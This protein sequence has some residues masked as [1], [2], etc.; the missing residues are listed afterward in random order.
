[1][2]QILTA[3]IA[4][5]GLYSVGVLSASPAKADCRSWDI[6]ARLNIAQSNDT[7]VYVDTTAAE[8][9]FAGKAKYGHWDKDEVVYMD[10]MGDL[11]GTLRGGNI[12]FT[13]RWHSFSTAVGN[14]TGVY[15]GTVSPQG[16]VTGTTYDAIH[17]GTTAEWWISDVLK[18]HADA[19][20]A[21][22]M[23]VR[24]PVALGRV[25]GSGGLS[26]SPMPT[27][28]EAARSARARN[29]PAAPGL[30]RQCAA[31]TPK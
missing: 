30:E 9:G 6:P 15:T 1:M 31:Q 14:S 2:K 22:P 5:A 13:I 26:D 23:P 12:Q 19:P 21:A 4:C 10:A 29:S 16:R 17:P 28:C 27:V 20:A 18:C 11:D 3:T 8:G 7:E 25:K 24:P